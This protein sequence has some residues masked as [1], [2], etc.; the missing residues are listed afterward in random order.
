[1]SDVKS[2]PRNEEASAGG[3]SFARQGGVIAQQSLAIHVSRITGCAI[4]TNSPS[5]WFYRDHRWSLI[6]K[7]VVLIKQMCG[8]T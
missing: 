7:T 3:N 1:M 8:P 2:L 4:S 6:N 5:G